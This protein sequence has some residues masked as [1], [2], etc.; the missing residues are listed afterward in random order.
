[1]EQRPF[2]KRGVSENPNTKSRGNFFVKSFLGALFV[3]MCFNAQAQMPAGTAQ[4]TKDSESLTLLDPATY[5][6]GKIENGTKP[7]A[8]F[9]LKNNTKTAITFKILQS[10]GRN[11]CCT[12]VEKTEDI[13]KPN[14]IYFI[15]VTY[16]REN[17]PGVFAKTIKIQTNAQTIILTVRGEVTVPQNSQGATSSKSKSDSMFYDIWDLWSDAT[18]ETR[19]TEKSKEIPDF[20]LKSVGKI[21]DVTLDIFLSKNS[22]VHKIV[23]FDREVATYTIK[24]Q[25]VW[26]KDGTYGITFRIEKGGKTKIL[27]SYMDIFAKE[28]KYADE[29]AFYLLDEEDYAILLTDKK[30]R[31]PFLDEK[32]DF[33]SISQADYARL[34]KTIQPAYPSPPPAPPSTPKPQASIAPSGSIEKIW[35]EH[36]V[37]E[38]GAYGMNVHCHFTINN[39]KDKKVGVW[40]YIADSNNKQVC[41]KNSGGKN[42]IPYLT[43]SYDNSEYKDFVIFVGYNESWVQ[44]LPQGKN[45][46]K[47]KIT[48]ID[49]ENTSKLDESNYEYFTLNK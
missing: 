37:Y 28:A 38:N 12:H 11:D 30:N 33:Y 40:L 36:N 20:V 47:L 29:V 31:T 18:D 34:V 19:K 1:M 41:F 43:P 23:K 35:L 42:S 39:K 46:L 17:S 6:F 4:E 22:I 32:A 26:G 44:L 27:I 5:D 45:D 49:R 25:K 10:C 7:T 14:E 8:T 9:R 24:E 15:K 3:L 16:V 21:Y 48:I 13:I 2:Q